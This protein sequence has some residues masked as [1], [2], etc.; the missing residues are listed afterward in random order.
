MEIPWQ[1]LVAATPRIPVM[2]TILQRVLNGFD[3]LFWA[4]TLQ[5][6]G[7]MLT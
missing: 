1:E 3:K 4:R 5:K 2:E 6:N 7:I